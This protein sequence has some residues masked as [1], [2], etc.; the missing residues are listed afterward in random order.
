MSTIAYSSTSVHR[1]IGLHCLLGYALQH[2]EHSSQWVA[3]IATLL[4][5]GEAPR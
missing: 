3:A 1:H 2:P 4:Q 5:R